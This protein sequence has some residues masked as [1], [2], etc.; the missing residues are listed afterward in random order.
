[1]DAF[2]A[3]ND[4][5][6][7]GRPV[8]NIAIAYGAKIENAI[9]GSGDDHILGNA[10]NNVLTGNA[11]NDTLNGGLGKDELSGGAGSDVFVFADTSMDKIRDF[12]SGTDKIDLSAFHVN[13]HA[14]KISGGNLF[15]DTDHNGSYDLHIV[16][17]GDAVHMSDILF[18]SSL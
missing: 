18:V 14:I 9:G 16:V 4:L 7:D 10:L 2:Y 15:A 13:S 1:M 12:H 6:P 17:Q 5:G 8:D 3:R 11:G